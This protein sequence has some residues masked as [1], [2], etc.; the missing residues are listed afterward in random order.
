[1]VASISTEQVIYSRF[2]QAVEFIINS[3]QYQEK[4]VKQISLSLGIEYTHFHKITKGLRSISIT[5][6][7]D[8]CRKYAINPTWLLLGEGDMI[9]NATN[10][11]LITRLE[12]LELAILKNQQISS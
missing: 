4:N 10:E 8:L 3:H 12:R 11:D 1:M 7:A 6:A 9:R 5:L 2:I